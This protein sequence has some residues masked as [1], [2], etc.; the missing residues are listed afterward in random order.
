M[1][2]V[3]PPRPHLTMELVLHT[4]WPEGQS[5]IVPVAV[6]RMIDISTPTVAVT[7]KQVDNLLNTPVCTGPPTTVY[8]SGPTSTDIALLRESPGIDKDNRLLGIPRAADDWYWLLRACRAHGSTPLMLSV[9]D[10]TPVDINYQPCTSTLVCIM[11]AEVIYT[12]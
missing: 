7:L 10:Q 9:Y 5:H 2:L 6:Q 4:V 1:I 12:Y 11:V 8:L 3:L